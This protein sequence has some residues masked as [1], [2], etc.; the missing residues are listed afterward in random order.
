MTEIIVSDN[1]RRRLNDSVIKIY[2]DSVSWDYIERLWGCSARHQFDA[3]D[4][5]VGTTLVFEDDA[6]AVAFTLALL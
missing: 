4:D 6:T 5:Y 3:N 1:T 2:G